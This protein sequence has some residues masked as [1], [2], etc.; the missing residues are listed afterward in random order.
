MNDSGYC[1]GQE[2]GVG[3]RF[4]WPNLLFPGFLN[5]TFS[6]KPLFA[7]TDSMPWLISISFFQN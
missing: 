2:A 4:S 3:T 1:Y 7:I 5:Y 6:A